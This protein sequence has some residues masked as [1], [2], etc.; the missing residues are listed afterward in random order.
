MTHTKPFQGL[1]FFLLTYLF[2]VSVTAQN[3][4]PKAYYEIIGSN[5]LILDNQGSTESSTQIF[6]NNRNKNQPSQVWN[7]VPS[8]NEGYYLIS[9]PVADLSMD[10]NNTSRPGYIIQWDSSIGHANQEW[11]ITPVGEDTYTLTCRASN[12]NLGYP[13]SQPGKTVW[14]MNPDSNDKS[15]VWTIKKSNIKIDIAT[16]RGSSDND[17][18]NETIFAINKER[19]HTT[20]VPFA[21][22]EE[23]KADPSYRKAWERNRS[24]RYLLLNGNW[25]FNWVK[26]P[27]E[28]P[29]NFYKKNYDVSGWKE[30][31]VPSNWEM[32]GYG[33]P[34]YTNITYPHKNIPP[35]IQ[36]QTGYTNEK[37]YNPVGSYRRDFNIPEDWKGNEIFLHFDGVYSAM[38]VWVNGKKVGYS[39]GSNNDAEFNIT[40]YVKIGD[41]TLAVEV[42][43]WCD[44]SYLEDQ[45]MFRLSGIH[46]DVYLFA[47]PKVHLRDYYFTSDFTDNL[48][49]VHFNVRTNV[50]NLNGK[51]KEEATVEITLLDANQKTVSFISQK[52][53][54]I[55]KKKEVITSSSVEISKP[56]LWSAETPYL[57]T[58]ILELKDKDGKTLEV[59][60]SQYGFRKIEMKNQQ[61]YINNQRIFF[62]GANRHDTHPQFGKAVPVSSMIQDILMF[63]QNNL[64]TIRTSHYPNDP[65]MYALFDYYGLYVMDEADVECHGNYSVSNNENW[66]PAFVDRMVRMIERDKNHPSVIFWSMGNECGGGNNFNTVYEEAKKLDDRMI[67]YEGKN[68]VADMDSRMYPSI[69]DMISQ[70]KQKGRN[71]PFFL[72]EYAHAMGNAIGNLEEYWNYIENESERMIGGCIWD[73]VD[74]GLNKYGEL[75]THYYYGGG[76]GDMPNSDNFCC[77]GIITPDR[78]VTPKLLEVKKVYQYVKLIPVNVKTGKLRIENHYN[79]LNLDNFCLIWTLIKD[80]RAVD[81]GSADMGSVAPG[82][83]IELTLPYADKINEREFFLNLSVILK[84]DCIWA[85]AGHEIACEQMAITGRV[86]VPV[87]E[88]TSIGE[89]NVSEENGILMLSSLGF[90][91]ETDLGKGI[92]TSLNYAG[93]EMI[94]G[95]EGFVLNW[96]RS[97]D[98]DKRNYW[99][100]SYG[101]QTGKKVLYNVSDDKK[102][103]KIT[104]PMVAQ[105]GERT[106]QAYTVTYTVYANGTVDVDAMFVA[107][108]DFNLPRLGLTVFLNPSLE[109]LQWYGRGPME[110][111]VDRQNAAYFG[112]YDNTVT[113]CEEAYV[114]PQSMGGRGDVRWLTVKSKDGAGIKIISRN[115]MDFSALHFT[116]SIL[117]NTKY[118][119]QLE[120][121]RLAQTV[122]N[123]DCVQRGLG[124]ASCGPGPRSEYEIEKNRTYSL[125]FRVEPIR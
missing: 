40:K 33:T 5:G 36:S 23:L 78:Q 83:F 109:Q 30:I 118:A 29:V 22:I 107:G 48:D 19:G 9:T 6:L 81:T 92:V 3:F 65:K 106:Q 50:V 89:L 56:F 102:F 57:Y 97:I 88:T 17:W 74:Q 111:Y 51:S 104:T 125:R 32:H 31:P 52:V 58:V 2:A 121:V 96:Y 117:W 114:R 60:S 93:K 72:C 124:N 95:K 75:P 35:F 79:F 27:K 21:S 115:Y 80:G 110:N 62:K 94:Y 101:L 41:N 38:Y 45:D 13:D 53:K 70:D 44:G 20:Y 116:D 46:R 4:D 103:V 64:N 105:I 11:K 49:K 86:P 120:N 71:K 16:L 90:R 28:R 100:T 55:R 59:M 8:T 73:W 108:E 26:D 42:Y 68:D 98:N 10:N 54:N 1:G 61:V 87:I 18:E 77:N 85:K 69:E 39:Q 15:Q 25:K 84:K 91:M 123:L 122:L 76:F 63:K 66:K 119:H 82:E 67:H 12:L 43:R 37:E 112:I 7:I 34:I 113:G 47:T 24:S 99:K 14:Q